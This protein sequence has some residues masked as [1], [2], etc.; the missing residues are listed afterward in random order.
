MQVYALTINAAQHSSSVCPSK[1]RYWKGNIKNYFPL[2]E[3]LE[4]LHTT[5]PGFHHLTNGYNSFA[6]NLR[7][8]SKFTALELKA[9]E[10]RKREKL[11]P[12]DR[13]DHKSEFF[14]RFLKKTNSNG[15][16][17]SSIKHGWCIFIATASGRID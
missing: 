5:S 7:A 16:R 10:T 4:C 9:K 3:T 12:P 13:F 11:S 17:H 14:K 2:F 6:N 8:F 1:K 15:T